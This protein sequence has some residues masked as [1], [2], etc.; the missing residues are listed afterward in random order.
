[1]DKAYAAEL[2]GLAAK[3]TAR[4]K[5]NMH[6]VP[7]QTHWHEPTGGKRAGFGKFGRPRRPTTCFM[8]SEGIPMLPRH[9]RAAGAGPAAE[10]VEAARRPRHLHP[11]LRHR[12]QMGHVRRRGAGRRRAQS[13]AASLRED[14]LRRRRPR[15]DRSLARR[16]QPSATSSNGRR[17][18][19]S[20][21][22]STPCTASSMRRR[23]R[24]C[25]CAAPRRRT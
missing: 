17:A 14:L 11:A 4:R 15:H 16:R 8:E 12:R 5:K 20:R 10:A 3:T 13:R 2:E 21:S 7:G 19:C 24:R 9:R 22:R 18:R 25:C 23:R 1:M 6:E